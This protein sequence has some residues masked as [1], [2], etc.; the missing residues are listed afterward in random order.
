[1]WVKAPARPHTYLDTKMLNNT[2]RA[3][4]KIITMQFTGKEWLALVKKSRSTIS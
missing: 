1:V 4:M 3:E 2:K